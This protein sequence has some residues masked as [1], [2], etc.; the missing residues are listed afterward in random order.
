MQKE[1]ALNCFNDVALY[2]AW[3]LFMKCLPAPVDLFYSDCVCLNTIKQR[4]ETNC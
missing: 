4:R 3:L 2:A 1:R